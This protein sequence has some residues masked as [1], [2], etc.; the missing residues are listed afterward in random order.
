MEKIVGTSH[1]MAKPFQP[2]LFPFFIQ[3]FAKFFSTMCAV[4]YV[5]FN[6]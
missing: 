6:G 2:T 1:N 5:E 4:I 3:Y